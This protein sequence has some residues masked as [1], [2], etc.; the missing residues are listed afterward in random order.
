M[1]T[2]AVSAKNYFYE[3]CTFY[4]PTV[5]NFETSSS[6]STLYLVFRTFFF[7]TA[8][9]FKVF[10]SLGHSYFVPRISYLHLSDFS[11]FKRPPY[12]VPR[13]SYFLLSDCFYLKAPSHFE[14]TPPIPPASSLSSP[15]EIYAG[16]RVCLSVP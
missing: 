3:P 14:E 16:C 1:A 8:S 7:K 13:T 12:F 15:V 10:P 6:V 11:Y 5:P 2:V 4:F 9:I